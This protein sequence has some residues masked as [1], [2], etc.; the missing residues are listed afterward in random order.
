[1]RA[2]PLVFL[3]LPLLL[4][5]LFARP[6]EPQASTLPGPSFEVGETWQYHVTEEWRRDKGSGNQS[7][8]S[9][10]RVLANNVPSS[11][12]SVSLLETRGEFLPALLGPGYENENYAALTNHLV[13]PGGWTWI[14]AAVRHDWTLEEIGRPTVGAS[15]CDG[16]YIPFEFH[17]P[18][19]PRFHLVPTVVLK[20]GAHNVTWE[21]ASR[22]WNVVV[23]L[24]EETTFR[25][26]SEDVPAAHLSARLTSL[27]REV[28]TE[29]NYWYSPRVDGLLRAERVSRDAR[30]PSD[31][32]T[33]NA[34][35]ELV[36]HVDAGPVEQIKIASRDFVAPEIGG[37]E[38]ASSASGPLNLSGEQQSV[39]FHLTHRED[40]RTWDPTE[41]VEVLWM[42][43]FPSRGG[44]QQST[45]RFTLTEPGAYELQANVRATQCL[46]GPWTSSITRSELVL[47]EQDLATYWEDRWQLNMDPGDV[48]REIATIEILRGA[49][50]VVGF[51]DRVGATSGTPSDTG[52]LVLRSLASNEFVLP[53]ENVV[54]GP[55]SLRWQ[56]Q[57]PAGGPAL[58]DDWLVGIQV[59]YTG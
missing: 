44:H 51:A 31:V 32:L 28:E 2:W 21:Y 38:I 41:D 5:V 1:M 39:E 16:H 29:L 50:T 36:S 15:P 54:P 42:L 48:E 24:E 56:G 40:G 52:R 3:L 9:T 20:G 55:Y 11:T 53:H 19:A 33:V 17:A 26:G 58:G 47:L 57:G 23:V 4:L 37:L 59:L 22:S 12:T 8:D 27:D 43:V 6:Q 25:W 13:D 46:L 30:D 34:A 14:G 10:V 35:L 49:S 18:N 7:W 45:G